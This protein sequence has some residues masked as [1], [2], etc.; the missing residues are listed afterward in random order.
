MESLEE[1]KLLLDPSHLHKQRLASL[2]EVKGNPQDIIS[3]K[4]MSQAQKDELNKKKV[5]FRISNEL[6]LRNHKELKTMLTVFLFK[7]L[8]DKPD[9]ILTYAG[10]FFDQLY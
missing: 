9:N 8:E 3:N 7:V 1:E 10:N 2:N 4:G 5:Q 6:Y